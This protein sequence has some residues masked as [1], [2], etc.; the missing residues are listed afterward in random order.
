M[1]SAGLLQLLCL[2]LLWL[3]LLLQGQLQTLVA[4]LLPLLLALRLRRQPLH[5]P[6]LLGL[7]LLALLAWGMGVSLG[8]RSALLLS[9]CNLLWL[10]SGLKLLEARS[11]HDQRRCSLLLLLAVGLAALAEQG[12]GASLLQGICTLLAL[13]SLLALE[14]GPSPLGPVLRRSGVL[15]ALALP[16][17]IAAFVLL[18]RLEPLWS[19]QLEPRGR[20]GLGDTLNPGALAELVEDNG[21]AARVSFASGQPPPPKQRYWRVLVHQ[22]FDGSSWSAAAV[23]PPRLQTSPSGGPTRERWLVEPNGLRQR[24]WSGAGLPTDPQQQLNITGSLLG[25]APLQERS[26]YGLGPGP[27][28]GVWRQI[29]PTALD[30]QLPQGANP[31]LLA[32]GQQWSRQGASPE[33]RLQLARQ[34][35]VQQGFRYTLE[36]GVLGSVDPLDRFLFETR[37][38]FC[39]HFAASFSALMRAAGVP[40]R[41]VVG[42]QGGVWQQPGGARYLELRNSDAHAWSEVWLPGQG[43]VGVDPTAWV[44]PERVRRSLAASLSPADQQ[45]LARPSPGWIQLAVNQWQGLDYRWQLW[46]M[47]FD[48]QRQRE[49][50]GDSSW[51]GLMAL[52][53]MAAALAIVLVPLLWQAPQGDTPRRQLEGLLRLLERCGYPLHPGES[54]ASYCRRVGAQVPA[55]ASPL[56][57]LQQRYEG[58]RFGP[59]INEPEGR[60]QRSE[61]LA[62]IACCRRQARNNVG[63]KTR[64][65]L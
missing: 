17:L 34:W 38:G 22:R 37:A 8:D 31:Q 54:L 48:R 43:W 2:A 25:R 20:T 65:A 4:V 23:P 60:R 21:L 46:V 29:A 13:G 40:A 27:G 6:I 33:G 59:A 16:L 47:G 56:A 30:L 49:L 57:T 63:R 14:G 24:P 42:Y 39:E 53:V 36:P 1:S 45:R 3:Q 64:R 26:L 28:A 19:L 50:L 41:V 12:L 61:L 32:L 62:A 15:V 11:H 5:Q 35:F 9:A 51:Q 7:T 52:G 18:P 58:W 55:L 10:L 44:V